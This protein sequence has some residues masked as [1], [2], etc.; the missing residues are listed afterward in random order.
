MNPERLLL[1]I[2]KSLWSENFS[3][4]ALAQSK[5]S[6]VRVLERWQSVY[7]VSVYTWLLSTCLSSS[8]KIVLDKRSFHPHNKL[9]SLI[10][11][12]STKHLWRT[13]R[14]S[15]F[16][17]QN[18]CTSHL[19]KN[20]FPSENTFHTNIANITEWALSS[21]YCTSKQLPHQRKSSDSLKGYV[22]FP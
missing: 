13:S 7:T 18:T 10:K 14:Q 4:T 5:H 1:R 6:S 16:P 20:R 15:Y 22:C 17:S 19:S 9:T 11:Q 3:G 2:L 21:A 12:S 8:W